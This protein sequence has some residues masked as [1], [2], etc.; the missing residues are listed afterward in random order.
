[1][2]CITQLLLLQ[3]SGEFACEPVTC[4]ISFDSFGCIPCCRYGDFSPVNPAEQVFS[5][6]YMFL[7]ILFMAWIIGS[8]TLLVVK[9]DQKTGAYR[10]L[11]STV[12]DY[13]RVNNFKPDLRKRLKTQLKLNFNNHD[14][15]D[16]LVLSHFP[17]STRRRILRRLYMSSLVRT[18]LL[19]GVRVQ[20][21]D[22][23]L[24]S[25]KVEIFGPGEELLQRGCV[26]TDL[27]LLVGGQVELISYL[28][29]SSSED[30][31]PRSGSTYQSSIADSEMHRSR[32]GSIVRV[33]PGD[34]INEISFFT[35]S[36]QI[37]T[38]RTVA[39]CKTLT[40]SRPAYRM[41]SDDHPGTATKILR[42][43]LTKVEMIADE[44]GSDQRVNLPKSLPVLQ[45]G[46]VYDMSGKADDS[47]CGDVN[48]AIVS[49]QT[50]N[51]LSTVRDLV[52]MHMEKVN[53]DHTT[54]FLFAASRGDIK[55][56]SLMCDQGFDP[57]EADYDQRTALMIAA[58]QG[59]TSIVKKLF[60]YEGTNPNKTDIH[61]N[62][63]LHEAV[64]CGHDEV[65][66]VLIEHGASLCMDERTA[67]ST[68]CQV[69]SEGDIVKM[70]RL[71]KAKIQ[72]NAGDYDKRTAAHIAAAEGNVVALKLLVEYG[73]DLSL[74]DRWN[75]SSFDEAVR[76]KSGQLLDYLNHIRISD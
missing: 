30:S 2:F 69:V 40:I 70:K 10:E 15:S 49:I 8:I 34:F 55:V 75:N 18:S 64:K 66:D 5:M 67:A 73:A 25:C 41:I 56:I 13:A 11:L 1:M 60:S 20:F 61:G 72:V 3:L 33:G 24:A 43:L 6:V 45:A 46:S 29:E 27:Y 36:P 48:H 76:S 35:G 71:L 31:V 19:E 16:E 54:R 12:D 74:R 42:N 22:E 9:S 68:L 17:S 23:L 57:N 62:S 65:I 28:N 50:E 47:L 58:V 59:N 53:D 26:A 39:I 51:T 7:N 38:I 14:I 4:C 32:S 52:R 37:D 21:L 63:A 44:L